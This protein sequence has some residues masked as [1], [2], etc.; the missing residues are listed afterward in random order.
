[1]IALSSRSLVTLLPALGKL[2][3]SFFLLIRL[4]RTR[5]H[6]PHAVEG[7][8]R[9]HA[10][11]DEPGGEKSTSAA[12]A[13]SAVDG[14]THILGVGAFDR[15]QAAIELLLRRGGVVPDGFMNDQQAGVIDPVASGR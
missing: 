13:G 8:L 9:V 5:P 7:L 1:M 3:D 14:H 10:L 4:Y 12:T 2:S 11:G 15:R 6:L